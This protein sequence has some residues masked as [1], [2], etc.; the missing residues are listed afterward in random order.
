MHPSRIIPLAVAAM[1][2]ALL[3]ATAP[4]PPP[5]CHTVS[6][7]PHSSYNGATNTWYTAQGTAYGYSVTEDSPI[8]SCARP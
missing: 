5:P 7:R 1:F 3:W 6:Q 2:A 8:E 4:K